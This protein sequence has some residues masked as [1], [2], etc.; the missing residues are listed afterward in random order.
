MALCTVAEAQAQIPGVS[1]TAE[2]AILTDLIARAGPALARICG[3]PPAS[4]G[5]APTMESASYTRYLDGPAFNAP[6]ELDLGLRPVTAITS[7]HDDSLWAYGSA[8]LVDSGDYV[9]SADEGRVLLAPSATHLWTTGRRN[10]KV[11]CTGGYATVPDDLTHA[12]VM[13]VAHWWR[14]RTR[15]GRTA[16]SDAR[17]NSQAA[18]ETIPAAARELLSPFMLAEAYV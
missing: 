11:V 3:F 5:A 14:L 13:T 8:T 18:P 7:I 12:A 17:G 6:R 16:Q 10:I 4:A 1:G 15:L 9:L 2:E